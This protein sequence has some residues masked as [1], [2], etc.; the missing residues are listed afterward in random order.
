M[1]D[2][3][4]H[5]QAP[6]AVNI[7]RRLFAIHP[8]NRAVQTENDRKHPRTARNDHRRVRQAPTDH[9]R[10][11]NTVLRIQRTGI[12]LHGLLQRPRHTTHIRRHRKAHYTRKDREIPQ[13][14]QSNIPTIQQF[15]NVRRLLQQRKATC[16]Y[17]IQNT[18]TSILESVQYV[19]RNYSTAKPL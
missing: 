1:T 4:V 8:G 15:G 6:L 16:R 9:H 13:D 11:R 18:L 5:L 3:S 2:R 7:H 17:R 19:L 14:V 12:L 10:S